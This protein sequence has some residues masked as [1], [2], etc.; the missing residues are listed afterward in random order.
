MI[1]E[2]VEEKVIELESDEDDHQ[3]QAEITHDRDQRIQEYLDVDKDEY[4]N[5]NEYDNI[6]GDETQEQYSDVS[7]HRHQE[8]VQQEQNLQNKYRDSNPI[9]EHVREEDISTMFRRHCMAIIWF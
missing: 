7:P 5:R 3:N 8:P 9:Q 6:V 1:T 4:L 2:I